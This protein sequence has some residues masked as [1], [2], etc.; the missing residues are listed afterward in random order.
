MATLRDHGEPTQALLALTLESVCEAPF[1]CRHLPTEGGDSHR[2]FD[3]PGAGDL[4]WACFETHLNGH[5][6]GAAC[7]GCG[8]PNVAVVRN[9]RY[10]GRSLPRLLIRQSSGVYLHASNLCNYCATCAGTELAWYAGERGS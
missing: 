8:A 2:C 9:T 10:G 1:R 6:D 5:P 4:C 3:H 7:A